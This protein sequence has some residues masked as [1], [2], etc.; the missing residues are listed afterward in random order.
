MSSIVLGSL[1]F[2][3]ETIFSRLFS[4]PGNRKHVASFIIYIGDNLG[5]ISLLKLVQVSINEKCKGWLRYL[6][7]DD[8]SGTQTLLQESKAWLPSSWLCHLWQTK[9][10]PTVLFPRSPPGSGASMDWRSKF[11]EVLS[12]SALLPQH[13]LWSSST[14]LVVPLTPCFL[15]RC[16][17]LGQCW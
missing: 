4:F 7:C 13:I 1:L 16:Q 10:L 6:G 2:T 8:V 17:A 9:Y 5:L 14:C 11:L 15:W 3:K 12:S